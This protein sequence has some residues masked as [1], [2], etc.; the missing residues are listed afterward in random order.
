MP[1][2]LCSVS[3]H[4]VAQMFAHVAQPL[5]YAEL[6]LQQFACVARAGDAAT[7]AS[8]CVRA[9]APLTGCELGQLYVLD[10]SHKCLERLAECCQGQGSAQ[11]RQAAGVPVDY[12]GEQLLQFALCQNRV[13]CNGDLNA[14]VYDLGFLK[15]QTQP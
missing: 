12:T 13:V 2:P 4:K 10:A 8:A 9:I 7:A 5:A 1:W 11:P 14:G 6:L 15:Q 3:L